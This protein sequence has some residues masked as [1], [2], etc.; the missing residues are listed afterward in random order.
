MT[1]AEFRE[2]CGCFGIVSGCEIRDSGLPVLF[3]VRSL[4][5]VG[6]VLIKLGSRFQVPGSGFRI[7][8]SGFGVQDSG[9][10]VQ[11]FGVRVRRRVQ[12]SGV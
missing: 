12:G 8:G 11:D 4:P 6:I 10:K 3:L 2:R 5:G 1:C 9:F 7:P